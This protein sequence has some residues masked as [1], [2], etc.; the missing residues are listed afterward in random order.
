MYRLVVKIILVTFL[1]A[2][3]ILLTFGLPPFQKFDEVAHWQRAVALSRGQLFCKNEHFVIPTVQRDLALNYNFTQVLE[4]N[5]KF[6]SQLL[7]WGKRW[8]KKELSEM[9]EIEKCELNFLGY[10]PNSLGIVLASPTRNPLIMFYSAR[11]FGFIFFGLVLWWTLRRTLEKFHPL[12][13]F[14]SL[15]PMIVHQVTV[16][17]YDVVIL[18]L[19][20]PLTSLLLKKLDNGVLVKKDWLLVWGIIA[21]L[22]IV[23]YVYLPLILI[24]L[25]LEWDWSKTAEWK[26][27]FLVKSFLGL[28]ILFG[29]VGVMFTVGKGEMFYPIFINPKIQLSLIIGDPMYFAQVLLNTFNEKWLLHIQEMVGIMG[30]KNVPLNNNLVLIIMSVAAIW[31]GQKLSKSLK[32]VESWKVVFGLLVLAGIIKLTTIIMYF[33]WSVP[34]N[35]VVEGIQG[36]YWLPLV[37]F[38]IIFISILVNNLKDVY[39]ARVGVLGV[40]FVMG[41]NSVWGTLNERYW[42]WSGDWLNGSVVRAKSAS[43]MVGEQSGVEVN[44][45]T[46]WIGTSGGSRVSGVA[47]ELLNRG[48]SII[49]PYKYEVKDQNCQRVLAKGYL[50]PWQIQDNRQTIVKFKPVRAPDNKL[51]LSLTPL[52]LKGDGYQDRLTVKTSN[53]LPDFIWLYY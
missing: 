53:N 18:S 25:V 7:E 16:V 29:L 42:D 15:M 40:I 34:G 43:E 24:F 12:I 30:W 32:K 14:Y 33:I 27:K 13:W 28:L 46:E 5:L 17:S 23:K 39:W 4:G 48:K 26:K 52:P 49:V 31:V 36:R 10:I 50:D 3:G 8:T 22:G 47:I 6:P 20:L 2:E 44:K 38:G 51:C 19:V 21:V 41:L 1:V 11:I 45:Q 35:R 9:S 37:P